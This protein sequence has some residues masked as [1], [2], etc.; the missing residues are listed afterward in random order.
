MTEI[1][2]S[3]WGTADHDP[4]DFY[5]RVRAQGDV[6]WDPSMKA[7][8]VVSA[9]AARQ[10]FMDDALFIHP[11]LTMQAGETYMKIRGDNP[12]SFFFLQG[13]KHREYH[14]WWIRDLL[15]PQWVAR[16]KTTAITPAL[17]R[18]TNQL[19]SRPSFD[20][21]SDYAERIPVNIFAALMD[22]PRQD[23]DSLGHIKMLNDRIADF[24]SAASGLQ[25]EGEA[26]DES[27]AVAARAIQA[28]K[29]LDD[30]LMPL[31]RERRDGQRDDLISRLWSGGPAIFPDWN[32]VDTLDGCRR[33]LFAGIDTT[34]H[35]IANAF[36][37][38]LTSPGLR[39]KLIAGGTPVIERFAEEALR[40]RGSVQ[41]RSRRA[42]ADTEL[43]GV[44]VRKGE[45]VV[46]LLQAANR[47]P[48]LHACPHAVD[49]ERAAPRN[50]LTFLYGPRSCPGSALAR[51]ELAASIEHG[52]AS[53]P[54]LQLDPV[55]PAPGFTGFMMRSY[56]PLHVQAARE[57][58]NA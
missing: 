21:V 18:L 26:S 42:T 3:Y 19:S 47:D 2:D 58:A 7:W 10:V 32:E 51:A 45:M 40:L 49:L 46:V 39:E 13:E 44:P 35:A 25:M 57:K 55:E 36:H 50:H 20:L 6:A 41:F 27:R 31:V 33:L 12:R 11:F 52:L 8:L 43:A 56:R 30:L 48:A 5:E 34:T 54:D 4:Y 23:G 38:L 53:F 15:S 22:L 29:E 9:A 16:Y 1:N 24:A 28:A 14:R 37:I 17:E